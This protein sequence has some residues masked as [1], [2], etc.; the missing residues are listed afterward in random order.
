MIDKSIIEK[1]V[2]NILIALGEDPKREGLIDTPKR[3]ANMF[4]E[5]FEGIQY[6]NAEIAE[7]FG[8][9]FSNPNPTNNVVVVKDIPAY[10]YCE[11]HMALMYNMHVSIAYVPRDKVIGLSKI[12]RIVDMVCRRLQLQERIGADVI[13]ILKQI[14]A[15]DDVLVIIEAEHSCITTRGIK[16]PGGKTKTISTSGCFLKESNKDLVIQ[17][18]DE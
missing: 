7:K 11:H 12:Y 1:S 14:V 5:V 4:E 8:K 10:S 18:L 17:L 6:S 2:K 3:V 9:C 15:C 16:V 13:D